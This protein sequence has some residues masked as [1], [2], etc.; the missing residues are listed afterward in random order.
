MLNVATKWLLMCFLCW[1]ATREGNTAMWVGVQHFHEEKKKSIY[2]YL[3]Y[4]DIDR[5]IDVFKRL[6]RNR[7]H[8]ECLNMLWCCWHHKGRGFKEMHERHGKKDASVS[9]D[10]RMPQNIPILLNQGHSLNQ[11]CHG[12]LHGSIYLILWMEGIATSARTEYSSN[13][14]KS[15]DAFT[16]HC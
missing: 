1:Q 8:R 5:W 16:G 3:F 12:S 4:I 2:L 11:W 14:V 13:H 10:I 9:R 6:K 15:Q 7:P